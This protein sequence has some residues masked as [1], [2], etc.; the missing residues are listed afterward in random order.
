[1]PLLPWS[2]PES[3]ATLIGAAV[4]AGIAVWGAA[5]IAT[6]RTRQAQV[7]TFEVLTH[8]SQVYLECVR[9]FV[10]AV[11][12]HECLHSVAKS[13]ARV[14]VELDGFQNRLTH[15]AGV[16]PLTGAF[17]LLAHADLTEILKHA[18]DDRDQ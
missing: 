12:N 13:A 11:R 7:A 18:S 9:K 1:L 2:L 3:S 17:G 8:A 16:M 6:N 4:G 5:W 15:L 14:T 10:L